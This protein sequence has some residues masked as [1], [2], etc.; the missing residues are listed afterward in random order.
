M[1]IDIAYQII[2]FLCI[3]FFL[4][5]PVFWLVLHR[6]IRHFRKH[7]RHALWM[8]AGMLVVAAV[9]ALYNI[10]DISSAMETDMVLKLAGAVLFALTCY[11][12]YK[13]TKLLG[14]ETLVGISEVEN[15]KTLMSSGIYGSIRHPKYLTVFTFLLGV[16]LITGIISLAYLFV[17]SAITF[18]LVTIEEERELERRLGKK[19]KA[20]KKK[21]GRFLPRMR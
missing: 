18:H 12:T 1:L 2:A 7:R 11:L 8:K 6:N 5:L 20:Y 13:T 17:Y 4:P 15:R 16:F 19:Y 9:F 10:K 3:T 21:T 14:K